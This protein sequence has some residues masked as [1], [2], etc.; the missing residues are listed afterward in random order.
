MQNGW[1]KTRQRSRSRE[2]SVVVVVGERANKVCP[3]SAP[4]FPEPALPRALS[5]GRLWIGPPDIV[6]VSECSFHVF[7]QALDDVCRG[8]HADALNSEFTLWD[9]RMLGD[10]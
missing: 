9:T 7:F 10:I 3:A 6:L 5:L 2:S 8:G 1:T 4:Y